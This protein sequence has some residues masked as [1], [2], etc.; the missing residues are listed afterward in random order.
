MTP[1]VRLIVDAIVAEEI[2]TWGLPPGQFTDA[3]RVTREQHWQPVAERIV[4]ELQ[5]AVSEA[6]MQPSGPDTFSRKGK[7]A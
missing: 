6:L 4:Q 3:L 7:A 2:A 5:K 1:P